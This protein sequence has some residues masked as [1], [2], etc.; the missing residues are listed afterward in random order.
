MLD[1]FKSDA[2]NTVSL[3]ASVLK[4]PYKPGLIG[5]LGLFRE[6][7]IR[8]KTAVVEEKD[9]QLT[10]IPTSPR[11][12]PGDTVGRK[13]RTARSFLVP[14]LERDSKVYADEVQGVRAFGSESEMESVQ[15]VIDERLGYLRQMHEVTLEYHR[16]GAI[17]GQILDSDGSTVVYNLFTEFGVSQQTH[18]I[19]LSNTNTNVRNEAVAIQRLIETELG[20]EPI[21]GYIAFCGDSFF[22]TLI[23]HSSVVES[24]KYQESALLRGDIRKGFEYGGITWTNPRAKVGSV[25]FFPDAQAFV[26]P[27]GTSIFQTSFAPA[28]YIEAVN[29]LGLPLYAKIVNDDDLNRWVK[30]HTQSNPLALCLRPRGVVQVTKS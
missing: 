11:G 26:V 20:A 2:F 19:A 7:G 24:L 21:T 30:V 16:A 5:S 28:D 8:D 27:T 17:Q 3:T 15:A 22:D 6:R 1:V 9:G 25:G 4:A 18:D 29:T 23:Q 13:L 10:L 12:G 14:H